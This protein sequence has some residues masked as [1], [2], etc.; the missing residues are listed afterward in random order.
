MALSET[1][2]ASLREAESNLR[3][4][5]AYSARMERPAVCSQIS[6]I[7]AEIENIQSLEGIMDMLE[8]SP[9]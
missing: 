2:V 9:K 4:A 5:L 8:S 3:N 7:I 1:V 6:K